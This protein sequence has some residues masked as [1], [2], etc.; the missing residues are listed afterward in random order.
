MVGFSFNKGGVES[1]ISNLCS[2]LNTEEFEIIYSMAQMVINGKTWIAPPNRHNP[3]KYLSFWNRFF[4]ENSFD[5]LYY[6]T[7]DIVSIDMLK[8]AKKAGIPVR[9]IHSHSTGIQQAIQK[10]M[11]PIHAFWEKKNHRELDKYAT[12]FLACSEAAGKWMFDMRD[13]T[14]IKNGVDL[15]KYK[16]SSDYRQKCRNELNIGEELLVGCIGRLAPEKNLFY[17]IQIFETVL[18]KKR[19]A[20]LVFIG[21]GELRSNLKEETH[22]RGLED[23][24]RFLG[25]QDNIH[26]WMSAIDCL[27]MPSLFEGLPFVL[28]EAQAAGLPCVVSSAVSEE[29]NLT[30]LVEYIRLD[31]ENEVWANKILEVCRKERLDTTRQLIEAGYSIENTAK[32]VSEIIKKSI[33]KD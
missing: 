30:G 24:I 7:C 22:K 4:K 10:K 3:F 26:E 16:F 23:K 31:E 14:I 20:T 15:R 18:K 19:E 21:D 28:V 1:Y 12:H 9:I 25:A 32:M 2:N 13:F 5:V 8:F 29:A 17:G 27:L 6:N 11:N 33:E